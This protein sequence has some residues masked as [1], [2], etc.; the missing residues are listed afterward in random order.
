LISKNLIYLQHWNQ[1][2]HHN[3]RT[4]ENS[5]RSRFQKCND[6]LQDIVMVVAMHLN[7]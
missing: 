5:Y 1:F 3:R 6:P 2:L 4:Q 7:S